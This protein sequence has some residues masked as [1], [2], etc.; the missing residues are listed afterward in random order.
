MSSASPGLELEVESRLSMD[1]KSGRESMLQLKIARLNKQ[2]TA[3]KSALT[4]AKNKM[5]VLIE[6]EDSD[7]RTIKQAIN[8]VCSL[9]VKAVDIIYELSI[10]Y[11]KV[12]DRTHT[13]KSCQ[14]LERV[15]NEVDE[16][17]EVAMAFDRNSRNSNSVKSVRSN[18]DRL[19]MSDGEHTSRV[20][21]QPVA[22]N[23]IEGAVCVVSAASAETN[24]NDKLVRKRM[25]QPVPR[26]RAHLE[27]HRDSEHIAGRVGS[28]VGNKSQVASDRLNVHMDP[29]SQQRH[30]NI[31]D[32]MWKQLKKV[33]IPIFAGDVRLY[34]GWKAAF[35]ACVDRAPATNEYKLLQLKQYLTGEPLQLVAK[36][37]HSATIYDI[38]LERL[39]R[40]YGGKRRYIALIMEEITSFR[41]LRPGNS[42]D[43]DRFADMLDV[44]VVRLREADKVEELGDGCLYAMLMQ[45]MT[46]PMIASFQRWVFEYQRQESVE[47]LRVWVLQE[48]QFQTIASE[49]KFGVAEMSRPSNRRD[50]PKSSAFFG[51]QQIDSKV[52]KCS[53]CQTDSHNAWNCKQFKTLDVPTRWDRAKE[54]QL[55]F[56]C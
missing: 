37:G 53:I 11:D 42:K 1:S 46:A 28:T 14:E 17:L 16:A 29:S 55:C 6:Q 24:R 27:V 48:T 4:K 26:T 20:E 18:I 21:Q 3:A 25:Q 32:D 23:S 52:F 19:F 49:V 8:Q 7:S 33:S 30:R 38:A 22:V 44:A 56:R 34:E 36:L 51:K 39:D 12:G 43:L 45:K 50:D 54:L 10:T 41:P 15:Q 5:L 9:Q 2:K 31:G 35:M 13:T 47:A 40:K